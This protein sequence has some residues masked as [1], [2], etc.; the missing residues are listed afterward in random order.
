MTPSASAARPALEVADIIRAH[1]QAYLAQQGA[2]L[3][4]GQQ[5]VLHELAVCRTAALGGHTEVCADCGQQRVSCI[6]S[7]KARLSSSSWAKK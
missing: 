3:S 7:M 1:G 6:M 4:A 5:R 2:H